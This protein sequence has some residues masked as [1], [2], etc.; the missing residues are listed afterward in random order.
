MSLKK[1]PSPKSY[2]P[3]YRTPLLKKLR[4]TVSGFI[5]GKVV[6]KTSFIPITGTSIT[7]ELYLKKF[8]KRKSN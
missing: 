2:T 8:M 3:L 6:S 7:F 5:R 1:V 4:R